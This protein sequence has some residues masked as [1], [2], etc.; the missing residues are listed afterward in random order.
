[1]VKIMEHQTTLSEI[2]GHQN[3]LFRIRLVGTHPQKPGEW[4]RKRGKRCCWF[5]P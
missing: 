1:M 5:S 3:A 4:L 2:M